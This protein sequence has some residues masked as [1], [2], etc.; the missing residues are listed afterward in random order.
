MSQHY[1]DPKRE[2]DEHALPDVE[3]WQEDAVECGCGSVMPLSTRENGCPDCEDSTGGYV[4]EAR[5]VWWWWSCF[6]GC[7]PDSEPNGPFDTEAEALRDAREQSG[8]CPHGNADDEICSE[9]PAPCLWVIERLIKGQSA[10]YLSFAFGALNG[11]SCAAWATESAAQEQGRKLAEAGL[12][13]GE[14]RT[15]LLPD[16]EAQRWGKDAQEGGE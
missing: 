5:N 1:S 11:N 6:P 10:G 7:L 15:K 3:V 16:D 9:C 14:W 2:A 4:T 8:L 12:L 13:V